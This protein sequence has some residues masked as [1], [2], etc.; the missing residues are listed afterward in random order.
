MPKRG[1]GLNY[2][3][4]ST[5]EATSTHFFKSAPETPKK[6]EWFQWERRAKNPVN[7]RARRQM[8]RHNMDVFQSNIF[9][10]NIFQGPHGPGVTYT[11]TGQ[12]G[13]GTVAKVYWPK[14]KFYELQDELAADK[15]AAAAEA[16]RRAA[17]TPLQRIDEDLAKAD[18]V[19]KSGPGLTKEYYEAQKQRTALLKE[20]PA[21][22][23]HQT[24]VDLSEKIKAE[25]KARIAAIKARAGLK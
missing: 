8:A 12:G 11:S 5:A 14:K 3:S 18:A 10:Q 25:R 19:I 4:K 22:V 20:R 15:V 2:P 17:L 21:A 16:K 6:G 23:R 13:P 9:Q 24:I 1:A 7:D